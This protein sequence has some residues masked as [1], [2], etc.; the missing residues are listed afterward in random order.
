MSEVIRWLAVAVAVGVGAD[1]LRRSRTLQVGAVEERIFRFFNDGPDVVHLPVWA[2][3]QAGSLAAVFAVG[4]ALELTDNPPNTVVV[5]WVGAAVWAGVKRVKRF[6]GR[7]RPAAHLDGVHVR[8]QAQTGLGYPSGH[9]AVSLT[10]ALTAT[11]GTAP[12][13]QVA[14]V[15]VALFTGGARVYVGAHLP[16]DVAGGLAIG[17]VVGEAT[18][19]ATNFWG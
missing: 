5:V 11:Q 18:I 16:I 3:M 12:G 2:V 7:G 17:V 6:A 10:L 8:G 19:A 13:V 9:A 14:A 4:A 1:T 15:G